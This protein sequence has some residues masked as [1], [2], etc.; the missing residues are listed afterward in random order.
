MTND[1]IR[2]LIID[3]IDAGEYRKRQELWAPL[4]LDEMPPLPQHINKAMERREQIGNIA[5]GIYRQTGITPT[6]EDIQ[7]AVARGMA[8][9]EKLER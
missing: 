5:R 6:N 3:T 1:E 7:K 8:L 9:I 2:D 4:M